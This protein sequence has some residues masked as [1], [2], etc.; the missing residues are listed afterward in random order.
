MLS[1]AFCREAM[2]CYVGELDPRNP[3][4]SPLYA[5]LRGLPPLLIHVGTH[6]LLLDDSVRFARKAS[7]AGVDVTLRVWDG[8]WH[9]FHSFD[10]P[11]A[12]AALREIGEFMRAHLSADAGRRVSR[13]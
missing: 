11:E 12:R 6:E 8:M 9:V 13:A 2:R 10:V 4:A 3:I 5:D 1:V 7:Q